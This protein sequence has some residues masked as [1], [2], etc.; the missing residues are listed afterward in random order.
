MHF[1]SII[2]MIEIITLI[3]RRKGG[4]CQR[5][6]K[7]F[8]VT[9]TPL[10]K[11]RTIHLYLPQGYEDSEERYPV[12]YMYD[13]HN[14]YRDED[15]TYGKSWGFEEFLDQYDKPFIMVGIECD[16]EGENRLSE[17]CPYRLPQSHFGKLDGYG[18][19]FMEWVVSELKPMID[20]QYRTIPFRECT[21]IGGASMGGLMALY[22]VIRFNQYFSKAACLSSSIGICMEE[23]KGEIDK[24]E[25]DPD[26]R[27]YL[28]WGSRE[29]RGKAGMEAAY[30]SHSELA[31][32]MHRYDVR[33]FLNPIAGGR[34]CEA[35]W[36]KQ[37]P[38]FMDYLWK[39]GD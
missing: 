14:L 18:D 6:I 26:T 19:V 33:T 32:R 7:K 34:H 25:M 15:A 37:I 39:Q 36:E 9:I 11:E 4:I 28:S 5:M 3:Q 17:Y 24:N 10:N 20:R 27:V 12:L 30:R 35:D 16:H 38:E 23:L 31:A 2:G 21:M 1:F 22:S 13:G 8:D 29:M